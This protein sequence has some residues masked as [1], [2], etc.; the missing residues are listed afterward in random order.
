METFWPFVSGHGA[1]ELTA[2]VISGAAGLMLAHA[3]IAPGNRKRIQALK[4]IAPD[5][6]KLIIGAGIMFF[7]AAFIEAF[8]SPSSTAVFIKYIMAAVFWSF[9]ILYFVFAGI[10]R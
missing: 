4:Y 6:L 1:F 3:V 2:I 7:I 9:V 5:A 10:R 8:W